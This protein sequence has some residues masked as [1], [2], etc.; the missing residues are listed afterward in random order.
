MQISSHQQNGIRVFVLEGRI[1]SNGAG[2]MDEALQHA[3]AGG[4]HQ[5]VLDLSG[6]SYINSAGLRTLADILTKCRENGG[7]MFLVA[8][9][10]KVDRVFRIIGFDKFFDAFDSV[11]AAVSSF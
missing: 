8:L 11:E 2:I 6:V 1:D 5:I 4:S 9:S 3:V 10:P 7:D